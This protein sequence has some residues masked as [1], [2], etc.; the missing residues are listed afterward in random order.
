MKKT[1]LAADTSFLFSL[2]GTDSRTPEAMTIIENH[3]KPLVLTSL[4][5]LEVLNASL[6][7]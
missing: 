3:S 5:D 6:L 2:L 4:N 7:A 1:I